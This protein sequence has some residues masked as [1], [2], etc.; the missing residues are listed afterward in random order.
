M[1]SYPDG[2][3]NAST[4]YESVCLGWFIHHPCRQNKAGTVKKQAKNIRV[5]RVIIFPIH[6][7]QLDL[8]AVEQWCMS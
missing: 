4:P 6:S 7:N 5:L 8:W 1:L 2:V 3:N